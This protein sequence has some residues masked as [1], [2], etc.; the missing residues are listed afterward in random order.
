MK[1]KTL[2]RRLLA[3]PP[4]PP[5]PAWILPALAGNPVPLPADATATLA[6]LEQSAERVAAIR[7]QLADLPTVTSTPSSPI[8]L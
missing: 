3:V 1:P 2:V 5:L 6:E 7:E 4:A 8:L